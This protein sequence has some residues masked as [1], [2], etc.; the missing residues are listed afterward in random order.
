MVVQ[1]GK[2]RAHREA[3]QPQRQLCELHRQLV[4]IHPVHRALQH[5]TPDDVPI[6]QV[7]RLTR[8]AVG[9]RLVLDLGAL[10]VDPV[11]QRRGVASNAAVNFGDHRRFFHAQQHRIGEAI[12]DAYQEMTGPHRRI[13]H[14]QPEQRLGGIEA[15]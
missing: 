9:L 15:A 4:A 1:E 3:V 8:P 13:G 10:G 5:D 12:D 2:R 11:G 7:L 6:I 14:P